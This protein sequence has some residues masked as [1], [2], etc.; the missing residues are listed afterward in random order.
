MGKGD[1][2]SKDLV[3]GHHVEGEAVLAAQLLMMGAIDVVQV[4]YC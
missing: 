2:R 3:P 1:E 4:V